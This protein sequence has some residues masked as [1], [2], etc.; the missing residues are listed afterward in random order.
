MNETVIITL[1]ILL[2]IAL[3][4]AAMTY[5]TRKDARKQRNL[6]KDKLEGIATD[7]Q[8]TIDKEETYR[9]RIVGLDTA[10]KMLVYITLDDK[11]PVY[12]LLNLKQVTSCKIVQLGTTLT[13]ENE[14]GKKTT[15]QHVM[16][17]VLQLRTGSSTL[18]DITFY[19]EIED[20]AMERMPLTKKAHEWCELLNNLMQ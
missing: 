16:L 15:E 18:A 2:C 4:I 11:E 20:G 12:H 17:V 10:K 6:L 9:N 3:V 19:S 5:K 8:L 13:E 1:V 7:E 14:K